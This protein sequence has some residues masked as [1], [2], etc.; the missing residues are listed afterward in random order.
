VRR[1]IDATFQD[2]FNLLSP[3]LYARR[4]GKIVAVAD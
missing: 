1:L 3:Q 4:G 2:N